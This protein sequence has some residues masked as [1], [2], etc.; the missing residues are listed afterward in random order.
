MPTS[1]LTRIIDHYRHLREQYPDRHIEHTLAQPNLH[2]ALTVAAKAVNA[3]NKIHHH[4][5]RNG[6]TA[7]NAFAVRLQQYER[8]LTEAQM[9]DEILSVVTLATGPR[10]SETAIYDTAHRI[11]L[12][13]QL[14]PEKI[15][16]NSGTRKGARRLLGRIGSRKF[17]LLSDMPPNF[18]ALTLPQLSWKTYYVYSKTN[19]DYTNSPSKNRTHA[20]QFARSAGTAHTDY[21][22]CHYVPQCPQE[23][24]QRHLCLCRQFRL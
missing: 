15:Y 20:H 21:G 24:A 3:R 12:Y 17:L 10:I 19:S 18:N 23:R 13:R 2:A 8:Q 4:Q 9:F 14:P 5:R 22:N 1:Y 16:L 7:L 6:R 11:G